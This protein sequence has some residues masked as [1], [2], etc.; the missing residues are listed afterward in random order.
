MEKIEKTATPSPTQTA[1]QNN[2][3]NYANT[4][5]SYSYGWDNPYFRRGYRCFAGFAVDKGI[6]DYDWINH[7]SFYTIHGCQVAKWCF[8]G[9]G[10]SS[11][12][13]W[14]DDD[15]N[16]DSYFSLAI[17]GNFRA[18]F[19]PKKVSPYADLRLGGL[20]GDVEGFYFVPTVGIRIS[21]FSMGVGYEMHNDKVE[22]Y[23]GDTTTYTYSSISFKLTWDWGA[24]R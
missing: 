3:Y 1:Q 10:I 21:H 19:V 9:G 24:R 20:L 15:D 13:Y 11:N 4:T 16:D 2:N 7:I 17:F 18:D 23:W 5:S 12:G 6:G 8:L 22:D 14:F